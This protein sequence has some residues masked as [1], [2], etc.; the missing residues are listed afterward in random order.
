[1]PAMRMAVKLYIASLASKEAPAYYQ[2]A[3]R[4]HDV[5]FA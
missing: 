5:P 4:R 2:H 3:D 1:M